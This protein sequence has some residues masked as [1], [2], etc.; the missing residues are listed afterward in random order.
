METRGWK[1]QLHPGSRQRVT[2]ILIDTLKK[3]IPISSREGL[4][5]LEKIAQK[6]EEWVFTH[7][8]SQCDYIWTISRKM[9]TIKDPSRDMANYITLNQ[10]G[11]TNE[12]E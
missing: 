5:E 10:V 9:C 4:N 11:T 3:H 12:M 8:T 1:S 6:Y 7:A 2:S